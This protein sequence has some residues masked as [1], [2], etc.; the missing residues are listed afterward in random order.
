MFNDLEY[1]INLSSSS[2]EL[3]QLSTLMSPSKI[4]IQSVLIH[5]WLYNNP[6]DLYDSDF[7]S[8]EAKKRDY[9]TSRD[10]QLIIKQKVQ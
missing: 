6:R 3:V 4:K 8:S 10:L 5:W 2:S 7:G 1:H 9:F